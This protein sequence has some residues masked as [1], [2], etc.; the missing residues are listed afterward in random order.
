MITG[1]F[2]VSHKGSISDGLRGFIFCNA[3]PHQGFLPGG[4]STIS[5]KRCQAHALQKTVLYS[6]YLL[7]RHDFFAPYFA[8]YFIFFHA[9]L[10]LLASINPITALYAMLM[11]KF[12]F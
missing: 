8:P 10:S 4:A 2:T 6:P 5:A 1:F 7:V 12:R 9:F 11:I 3:K